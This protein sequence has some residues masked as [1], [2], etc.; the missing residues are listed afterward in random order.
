MEFVPCEPRQV[1]H[2]PE[3]GQQARDDRKRARVKRTCKQCGEKLG[4]ASTFRRF[5]SARCRFTYLQARQRSKT[6]KPDAVPVTQLL[7]VDCKPQRCARVDDADQVAVAR[8]LECRFY[9]RCLTHA[10]VQGWAG[11]TCRSCPVA[12]KK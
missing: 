3:C 8:E 12:G 11:F 10:G 1:Y 6:P 4:G 5:C 9:E 2:S 7:P